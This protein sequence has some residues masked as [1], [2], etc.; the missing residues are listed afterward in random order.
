MLTNHNTGTEHHRR[1]LE[2]EK[3]GRKMV[4]D[5]S[6]ATQMTFKRESIRRRIYRIVKVDSGPAI[7]SR[8]II[9]PNEV[10]FRLSGLVCL[11]GSRDE[12]IKEMQSEDNGEESSCP[13]YVFESIHTIQL[14]R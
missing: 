5:C 12:V 3:D 6:N 1:H 13:L 10:V 11:H 2:A 9:A 8:R 4:G 14:G 7:H